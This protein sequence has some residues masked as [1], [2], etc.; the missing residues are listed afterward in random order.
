MESPFRLTERRKADRMAM[1]REV[2]DLCNEFGASCTLRD[3]ATHIRP[4]GS[5]PGPDQRQRLILSIHLD[6]AAVAIDFDGSPRRANLD[7]YCM[8]W[9]I[10]LDDDKRFSA[11]FGTAAG[12]EVNPYHRRKCMGFAHGIDDLLRR[13]RAAL[14]CI[15]SPEAFIRTEN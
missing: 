10:A 7:V 12:A 6:D 4:D 11:A 9:N 3:N 1:A 15:A 13:L 5:C 8:P 14:E 2:A